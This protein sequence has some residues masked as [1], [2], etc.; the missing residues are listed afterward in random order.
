MYSF[1]PEKILHM[2][3]MTFVSLLL[4]S[5]LLLQ[6]NWFRHTTVTERL[7]AET[8]IWRQKSYLYKVEIIDGDFHNS[9]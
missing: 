7:K 3:D 9:R 6:N 8:E 4:F 2:Q 1:W 5:A